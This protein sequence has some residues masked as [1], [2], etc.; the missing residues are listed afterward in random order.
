MHQRQVC[1]MPV[2]TRKAVSHSLQTH[3]QL[4]MMQAYCPCLRFETLSAAKQ[5]R[6]PL[7]L[8]MQD[9]QH[10]FDPYLASKLPLL[11][12]FSSHSSRLL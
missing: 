4:L 10:S 12:F 11:M 7:T 5:L 8:P 9:T 1:T 2:N 6:L 3:K